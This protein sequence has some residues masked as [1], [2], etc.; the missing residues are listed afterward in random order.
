M[1]SVGLKL[2]QPEITEGKSGPIVMGSMRSLLLGWGLGTVMLYL[3]SYLLP[4]DWTGMLRVLYLGSGVTWCMFAYSLSKH[5]LRL[6]FPVV[7]LFLI[8]LWSIACMV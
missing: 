4:M 2:S 6:C 8:Q 7:M 5:S 1:K 3:V